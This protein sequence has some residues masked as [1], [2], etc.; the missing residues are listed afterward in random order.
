[1]HTYLAHILFAIQW[2][3]K[4]VK[5]K[6]IQ[7]IQFFGI[8]V[9]AVDIA[10]R[11]KSDFQRN[12]K[13]VFPFIFISDDSTNLLLAFTPIFLSLL[14]LLWIFQTRT[15]IQAFSWAI[16]HFIQEKKKEQTREPSTK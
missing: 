13:A 5:L 12:M 7:R 14:S 3:C 9:C 2:L 8:F 1:M 6:I 4:D 16:S 10:T 11:I 15:H